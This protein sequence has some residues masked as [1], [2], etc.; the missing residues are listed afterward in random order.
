MKK[1][2]LITI[3][4]S[5]SLSLCAQTFPDGSFEKNW[6]FF[7]N[8]TQGKADYWDFKDNYFLSTLNQLHEL[9]GDQGDAPLTAFRSED[10]IDGNYALK[11]VSNTMVFGEKL[12]LPGA[13]ATLY[14][15]FIGMDCIMGEPFT[16]KPLHL[17]GWYKCQLVKG[18]SAAIEVA[19]KKG[20]N[21]IGEGKLMIYSDVNAWSQFNIPI[22]Y[23]SQA[24]PDSIVVIFASSA[25][26][27]FTNIETLMQCKG[28]D[29][30]TLYIDDVAFGYEQ[31]V[32][33][34]MMPE[35]NIIISPNP[36]KDN[37]TMAFEK[38]ING[39]IIVYDYMGKEI[40]R[41]SLNGNSHQLNI[42]KYAAGSYFIN[43]VVNDKLITSKRFIKE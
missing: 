37:L 21:K 32:R 18:D 34:L 41:Y 5:I 28:Q 8:P 2:I 42:A 1:I 39:L 23:T 29:G 38:P 24:S 27:D 33:E 6:E 9:S 16:H 17:I 12:F 3:I 14:I 19:L 13:A 10:A 35:T 40:E 15:D 36:A 11:L 22:T 26:Y 4:A 30:S 20:G 7:T 31:N 43:V 25:G